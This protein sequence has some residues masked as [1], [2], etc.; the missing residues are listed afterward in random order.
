LTQ[1]VIQV[2]EFFGMYRAELARILKN[3]LLLYWQGSDKK[4]LYPA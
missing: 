3:K 2:T 1:A 4:K